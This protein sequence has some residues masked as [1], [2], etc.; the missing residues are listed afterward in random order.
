MKK[1]GFVSEGQR[2]AVMALLAKMGLVD[3]PK[4]GRKVR[5]D[6][7]M[8]LRNTDPDFRKKT[9]KQRRS[10]RKHK[11]MMAEGFKR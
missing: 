10:L 2:A 9:K 11:R 3:P 8:L 1:K 7:E 5:M 4:R 6:E